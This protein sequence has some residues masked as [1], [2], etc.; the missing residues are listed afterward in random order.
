MKKNEKPAVANELA[1]IR[2]LVRYFRGLSDGLMLAVGEVSYHPLKDAASTARVN[3]Y[4]LKELV[5]MTHRR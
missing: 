4:R 2:K 3:S 5:D 1:E